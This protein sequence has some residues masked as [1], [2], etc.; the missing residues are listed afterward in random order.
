MS[1]KAKL[2]WVQVSLAT[3][4]IVVLVSALPCAWLAYQLKTVRDREQF[5]KNL[6]DI[7]GYLESAGPEPPQIPWWRESLGDVGIVRV[8]VP[9][10][11]A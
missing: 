1:V 5:K 6:W 2:R 9:P 11:Y 4:L 3:M 10:A 7:G 8:C